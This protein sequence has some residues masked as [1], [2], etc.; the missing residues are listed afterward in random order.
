VGRALLL[1]PSCRG[2]MGVSVCLPWEPKRV[3]LICM[4]GRWAW[5]PLAARVMPGAHCSE[6][7]ATLGMP[8]RISGTVHEWTLPHILGS[9]SSRAPGAS[10]F[11][12]PSLS[13]SQVGAAAPFLAFVLLA[14]LAFLPKNGPW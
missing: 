9:I 3:R 4:A 8:R 2:V 13:L 14:S 1:V 12:W 7:S 5:P 11:T 10:S 6:P